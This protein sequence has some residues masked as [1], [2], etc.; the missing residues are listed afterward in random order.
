MSKNVTIF[1]YGSLMD[2]DSA[3]STLPSLCNFRRGKLTGYIRYY[4][5]VS[6]NAI[7]KGW[8]D[9]DTKEMAGLSIRPVTEKKSNNSIIL[10]CLFEINESDMAAYLEREHRYKAVLVECEDNLGEMKTAWT[11]VE[12]SDDAYKYTMSDE[13]YYHR[14]AKYY[15]G[16]LWGRKDIFPLRRY[17]NKV[18]L[19]AHRLGGDTYVNNMLDYTYIA[20]EIQTLREY[21]EV[22]PDRKL[23]DRVDFT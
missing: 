17:M 8:A 12:Q 4:N 22:Y 11:V 2:I 18:I 9:L 21:L 10:G 23:Y 19:A 7:V 14:V 15:E 3:T 20:N 16:S 1:G 13:E 5:L 6:V